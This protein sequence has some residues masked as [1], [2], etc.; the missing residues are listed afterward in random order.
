VLLHIHPQADEIYTLALQQKSLLRAFDSGQQDL[1]AG[2]KNPLPGKQATGTLQRPDNLPCRAGE[3]SGVGHIAVGCDLAAR[4]PAD[5]SANLRE[6][7]VI[8]GC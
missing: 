6:H 7:A 4:D 3:T 5:G 1:A 8:G 2:A